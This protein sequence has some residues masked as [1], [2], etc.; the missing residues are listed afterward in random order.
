[1]KSGIILFLVTMAGSLTHG[2]TFA[3]AESHGGQVVLCPSST[4]IMLD[5]YQATLPTEAGG[6]PE[7]VDI[8]KMSAADVLALFKSR[9]S[10]SDLWDRYDRALEILGPIDSWLE[11]DLQSV[12]DSDPAY[13]LPPDCSL[14]QVAVRQDSTM[15]VDPKILKELS[16]AQQGLLMAHEALY[17]VA[18][19]NNLTSSVEVRMVVR[20]L[21]LEN[22]D[23]V[24]LSKAVHEMGSNFFWWELFA[25]HPYYD[26]PK[27][28]KLL[29]FQ[30]S[31]DP[32]RDGT[33]IQ[34]S[35]VYNPT[36]GP[37][38]V[39]LP[40]EYGTFRCD[41]DMMLSPCHTV[42]GPHTCTLSDFGWGDDGSE[43]AT[44]TCT[45]INLKVRISTINK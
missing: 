24:A 18:Q 15:Y 20:N 39:Q 34:Y 30:L 38:P 29:D 28:G 22:E 17:Y 5:Y 12:P 35:M 16:P 3:G 9:L 13:T 27:S 14:Q 4:P 19:Q 26:L 10:K 45:D 8:S 1:M 7:L 2:Q 11:G 42:A 25:N 23:L 6:I 37:D 21:L 32:M 31:Y 33:T 44:L 40:V 43:S 36:P 41:A